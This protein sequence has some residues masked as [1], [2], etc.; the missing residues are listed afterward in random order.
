MAMGPVQVLAVGFEH[1]EFKGEALSELKKLMEHDVVRLIDLL[2]LRRNDDDTIEK[3]EITDDAEL[4]KLGAVVGALI[5][6]GAAGEEGAEAGAQA[7][8]EAVEG[9]SLFN[10]ENVWYLADALPVGVATAVVV[11]E[12]RWAIPLRDAIMRAGGVALVDQWIQPQ[13]LVAI[14]VEAA[15]EG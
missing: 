13:D 9:G 8:V 10:E 6:Y 5:G 7:G 15:A 4:N 14:G 1:G 3:I 2:F 11:L 12:H